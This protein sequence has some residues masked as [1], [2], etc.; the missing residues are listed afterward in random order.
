M[1]S[2]THR[3]SWQWLREAIPWRELWAGIGIGEGLGLVA[4]YFW[5]EFFRT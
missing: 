2:R 4:I 5:Y 3:S 1:V